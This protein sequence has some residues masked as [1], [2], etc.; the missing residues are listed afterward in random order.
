RALFGQ[1]LDLCRRAGLARLGHVSLDGTKVR[2]NASKHKA[3][4]Y[5]RMLS[6]ERSLQEE[7]ERWFDEAER[8]DAEEDAEFGPDDDGYS[9]PEELKEP[10]RR[11]AVIQA[12]KARLEEEARQKA[13][14]VGEDPGT[15]TVSERAQTNFT[16][17]ESRIMHT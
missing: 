15:A 16:D 12:A 11:L 6:K 5:G 13:E 9:L 14:M 17:P 2:A 10:Q 4:S 1:I 7:V 8:Q 3:M